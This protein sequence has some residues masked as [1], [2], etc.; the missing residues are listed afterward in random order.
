MKNQVYLNGFC[1]LGNVFEETLEQISYSN[2]RTR[3]YSHFKFDVFE[4]VFQA[5]CRVVCIVG[6]GID[7][8]LCQ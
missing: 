8:L 7:G 3:D 6:C 2:V 1:A 4:S 5:I